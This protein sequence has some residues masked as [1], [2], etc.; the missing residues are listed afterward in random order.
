VTQKRDNTDSKLCCEQ[1]FLSKLLPSVPI[2]IHADLTLTLGSY[3]QRE[4]KQL[5]CS[6]SLSEKPVLASTHNFGVYLTETKK[7]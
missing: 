7:R 6:P 5:G 1:S 3:K 4:G 2:W